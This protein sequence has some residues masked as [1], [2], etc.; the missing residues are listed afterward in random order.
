MALEPLPIDLLLPQVRAAVQPPGSTLLLQAPPGAGKTTRVPAAI[1]PA[2]AG[3][4]WMLEPRRIAARTA[5]QRLAAELGEP[6]GGLVGYSVRLE[7]RTSSATRIELLTE[8]LFLRRLQADPALEGVDCVVFDEFH[9]RSADADLALALLRQGR[10]LL[11]PDLRLVV[12]SATLALEPLVRQLP[13]AAVLRS[14]GRCFPVAISHQPPRPEERLEHQVLRALEQHWLDQRQPGQS[15]LV[16]LPGRREILRCE[17]AIGAA[18]W[19]GDLE[20]VPLH[21]NLSLAEQGRAI[22]AASG[23]AGKVVLATSIAES[24]LTIAGVSLVIDTGLSRRNRFD[25][26]RGM[27][28]LVTRPASLASAE[29]RAGR[30][31][32]LAP[33]RCVRLWSVA[34]QRQR[35]LHDSP[36]LLE[37]DP[38]P[39][40][41]QLARWGDPTG[42]ELP[43]IDP[44]AAEPLLEARQLLRQLGGLDP[45]GQLSHHGRDMARLGLHPR[46]AHL[47]LVGRQRGLEQLACELAVLLSE[48]DPL[49]R[50]EAGCDLLRRL[51]WLRRQ[52]PRQPMQQLRRR[53]Q[54]QVQEMA[55]RRVPAMGISQTSGEDGQAALLVAEA[56]PERLAL[57]RA[58]Q[59]GRF[60]LRSGQG[61]VL[62]P[63]D[64]LVQQ[65]ALAVAALD[66]EGQDARIQLAL[67]LPLDELR[68]L[69]E[70]HGR[71]ETGARWDAQAARVRCERSLQLGALVLERR[72]WTD[73]APEQVQTALLA[74]LRRL[75]LEALPWTAASRQL[76]QRLC[77]AHR[78]RGSP[79]PDRTDTAL[80]AHLETWLAPHLIGLS[81]LAEVQQLDLHEVLWGELDWACR[82]DLERLLPSRLAVPS[83]RS[84]PL[85]YASGEPVLAVKL[86]E[87]F[88]C[89]GTPAVLDGALP[90]TLHLLTPAGR[91]AAITRDL[92]GFWQQGY[93]QVRRELRGRY[94]KHPWPEDGASAQPTAQ[95]KARQAEERR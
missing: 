19:S 56:F 46:L 66:G 79:W 30:A 88:G 11:R 62:H 37:S 36:E 27:D 39:L 51:D 12:M 63:H 81:S 85:D 28:A 43:W 38:L 57:A 44:P 17:Q 23:P 2:F 65:A 4:V 68:H 32:R 20:V 73:A 70:E 6:L 95:T 49:P 16:F 15:V 3:R 42:A 90:V 13:E 71:E 34:D 29:Q 67:P 77:L 60:L 55:Q 22:A 76:Q 83:G 48:R 75:G 94:P 86:Q 89:R 82:Q 84:A 80:A 8:G 26:A 1:Q 40:A 64:P 69:A 7:S 72:P 91:T 14:A 74:G 52:S 5:A 59:P 47:L 41:L 25:P 18:G 92:D 93:G 31:G 50:D 10:D 33:G 61:A 35:P 53:F 9:E 24:S 21:G 78:H 54:D 45:A 58:G 87:L